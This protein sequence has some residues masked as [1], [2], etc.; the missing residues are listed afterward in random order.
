M[1]LLPFLEGQV[2]GTA[3]VGA[4]PKGASH[5]VLLGGAVLDF[6]C[7]ALPNLWMGM[8]LPPLHHEGGSPALGGGQDGAWSWLLY[9]GCVCH[10]CVI[11]KRRCSP[12]PLW[13]MY[14]FLCFVPCSQLGS[15]PCL[16]DL[17]SSFQEVKAIT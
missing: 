15:W 12:E 16:W 8:V 11:P 17:G 6:P 4:S 3:W 14:F 10:A 5:C 1:P 9:T 2:T 13:V 7:P